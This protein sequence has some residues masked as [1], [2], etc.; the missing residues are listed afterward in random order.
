MWQ[1]YASMS[2]VCNSPVHGK[3]SWMRD[4]DMGHT[5]SM[6]VPKGCKTSALWHPTLEH[7]LDHSEVRPPVLVL[8]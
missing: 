8:L 3:E 1:T 2:V 6:Q 5:E 7:L 4:T